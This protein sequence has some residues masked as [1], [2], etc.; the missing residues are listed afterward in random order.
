[1]QDGSDAHFGKARVAGDPVGGPGRNVPH[2][3][4]VLDRQLRYVCWNKAAE[5]LTGISAAEALGRCLYEL[6]PEAPGTAAESLYLDVLRT[7][8]PGSLLAEHEGTSYEVTAC[9]ADEGLTVV[10]RDVTPRS[11]GGPARAGRGGGF[12]VLFDNAPVAAALVRRGS[13]LRANAA[14][15]RTFAYA[16]DSEAARTSLL[17][18]LSPE[19]RRAAAELL[20]TTE[21]GEA[22]HAERELIGRGRDGSRFPVRVSAEAVDA[23]GGQAVL[24]FFVRPEHWPA[25]SSE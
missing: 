8:R 14:F 15:L 18:H 5:E 25:P 4:F 21:L 3:R 16:A 23:A 24:V 1:V 6:F 17:G 20:R 11:R 2:V 13:I 7:R 9:P 19:C 12:D 22:G 10:A